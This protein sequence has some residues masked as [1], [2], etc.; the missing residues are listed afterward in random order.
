M[1]GTFTTDLLAVLAAMDVAGVCG[2]E[3]RDSDAPAMTIPNGFNIDCLSSDGE[4][5]SDEALPGNAVLGDSL[6]SEA[7]DFGNETGRWCHSQT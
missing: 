6:Q 2:D 1:I 7:E 4:E 3:I 5:R